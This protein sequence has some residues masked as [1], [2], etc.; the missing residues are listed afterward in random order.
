LAWPVRVVRLASDP[1]ENG[2]WCGGNGLSLSRYPLLQKTKAGFVLRPLPELQKILDDAYGTENRQDAR[3]Y[4]PG[5]VG[6][7]LSLS[8][9]D[10]PLAMIGSVMLKLPDIVPATFTSKFDPSQPRDEDGRW[11]EGAGSEAKQTPPIGFE[12]NQSPS[13]VDLEAGAASNAERK[14]IMAIALRVIGL[15]GRFAGVLA[16]PVTLG[17]GLLIPTNR[18][19]IHYGD[20]PGFPG[21]TFRSDEGVV[22]LSRLDADGNI[23]D[24]Y[25]GVPDADGFYHD[26]D[27]DII[28]RHVGTGVLFDNDAL[29]EITTQTDKTPKSE[30]DTDPTPDAGAAPEDDEPKICPAPSVENIAGRSKRTIAYQSQMTGLLPG[31]DMEYRTVRFDGCD[32]K[33]GRMIEAKGLG[34]EW[35]LDWPYDKLIKSK[36]YLRMMKQAGEQNTAAKG[37]G[38]D[39]Y[40]ADERMA[41]FFEAEFERERYTNIKVHHVDA[42][43]KKIEDCIVWI[44]HNSQPVLFNHLEVRL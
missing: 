34:M 37:R 8:K 33:T 2:L 9:G 22:T 38:D 1:S 39:Y 10:L 29:A 14:S 44:R 20:I 32:E 27:G 42:V 23:E 15:I 43:V 41:H 28:G 5:L 30:D 25:H 19:N 40:F 16:G 13:L 36:F 6:V 4:V 7:A 11:T 3:D 31:F 21:L 35:M 12:G 18:S 26:G 17:A 24:L